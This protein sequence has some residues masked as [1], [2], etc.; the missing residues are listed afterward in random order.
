MINKKTGLTVLLASLAA[1]ELMAGTLGNY[2][3]GDVLLCFRNGSSD[4]VVDV[5]QLSTLTNLTANARY[6]IS[7]YTAAQLTTA[8]TLGNSPV[9]L[10]GTSWSAFSWT[11]D[12]TLFVTRPRAIVGTQTLPWYDKS[13]GS[14]GGVTNRM[15]TIPPGAT[16]NFAYDA[17]NTSTA[18]LEP[19]SISTYFIGTSYHTA[20]AGG[21]G[22]NFGG[23]FQGN[24][25]NTTPGGFST[26]GTV[27]RSD[28]YQMTPGGSGFVNGRYLGYFE[29]NTNGVMTYVAFPSSPAIFQSISRAGNQTTIYYTTGTNGTY[30]LRNNTSL[31]SGTPLLGWP[32]VSTLT[33]GDTATHS[34]T[35]TDNNSPSFYTITA[36]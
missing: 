22:G 2:A 14:Q 35:F 17:N 6:T 27:Q 29:L 32:S 20:E 34:I 5:G 11:P 13:F 23:T 1:G 30:T 10:N 33:S 36:Q 7:T 28:F 9:G 31:T 8:G 19:D 24:P 3:S 21:Y 4:L 18:I 15:G 16:N 26:G 12:S 25:E